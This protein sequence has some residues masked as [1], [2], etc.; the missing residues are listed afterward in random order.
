[1]GRSRQAADFSAGSAHVLP[2]AGAPM[3]RG[4]EEDPPGLDARRPAPGPDLMTDPLPSPVTSYTKW[5]PLEEMIVGCPDG[6]TMPS[7]HMTITY[8]VP[9]SRHLSTAAHPG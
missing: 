4:L 9:R 6:A 2:P 1:M 3:P 8:N 5:D 7:N